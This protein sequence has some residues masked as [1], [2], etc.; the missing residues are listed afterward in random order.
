MKTTQKIINHVPQKSLLEYTRD[1]YR[2]RIGVMIAFPDNDKIF[3][4]WSKCKTKG[5]NK[6]KFDRELGIKIAMNRARKYV[7]YEKLFWHYIPHSMQKPIERFAIK[8][9][10]YYT[11]N[12]NDF[13]FPD[14]VGLK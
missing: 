9:G 13:E 8:C 1:K 3:I 5:Q 2:H 11:K 12:G 10:K 6:D 4:G 7:N 14:W